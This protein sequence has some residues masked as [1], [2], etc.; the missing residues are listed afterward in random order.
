MLT[1]TA[2]LALRSALNGAGKEQPYSGQMLHVLV[3]P[4]IA[5]PLANDLHTKDLP[6]VSLNINIIQPANRPY[7]LCLRDTA[8]HERALNTTLRIAIEEYL[9]KH[10]NEDGQARSICGWLIESCRKENDQVTPTSALASEMSRIAWVREPDQT[11]NRTLFRYWDP[12]ITPH[13]PDLLG[14]ITWLQCQQGLHGAA[15]WTVD[16][17]GA[18]NQIGKSNDAPSEKYASFEWQIAKE[19]WQALEQIGWCNRIMQ[20]IPGWGLPDMPERN[21]VDAIVKRGCFH[22]LQTESDILTFAFN[23][24]TVHPNFDCH[25]AVGKMLSDLNSLGIIAG[26]FSRR[27]GNWDDAFL[28]SLKSGNWMRSEP[29]STARTTSSEI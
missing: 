16:F 17:N 3:D 4:A 28:S 14:E 22:G 20:L 29:T 19:K 24:L 23:A 18:F 27:A 25:P 7:L 26:E 12:R 13:L 2:I 10:D 1:D 11:L 8:A 15:W 6:R 21:Q 5:D 9:G